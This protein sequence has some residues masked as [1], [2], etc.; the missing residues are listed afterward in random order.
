MLLNTYN[1][2][3]YVIAQS[4]LRGS[5]RIPIKLKL[6]MCYILRYGVCLPSVTI[7]GRGDLWPL[8]R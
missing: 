7:S 2:V 6:T 8:I 1:A 5:L 4:G 3:A